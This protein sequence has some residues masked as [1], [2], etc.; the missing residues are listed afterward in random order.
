MEHEKAVPGELQ[1]A[2]RKWFKTLEPVLPAEMVGLWRGEG[3]P[4]DHPL[5]GVLENLQWFGKRFHPDLR[6]DALL[7][8]WKPNRLVPLKPAAFPIRLAIALLHSGERSSPAN[9][10]CMFRRLPAHMG[11]RLS[12]R[13]A[14][15]M[16][17]R[18]LP[19]CTTSCLSSMFS[20]ASRRTKSPA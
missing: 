4:S 18:P 5:D 10:S 11:Q 13:S 6:A 8:Q 1:K 15:S 7:F 12:S 19:W 14:W 2:R 20:D 9:S 16:V 3:I 17:S